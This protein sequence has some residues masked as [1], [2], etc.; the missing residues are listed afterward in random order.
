M[1]GQVLA[2]LLLL[3]FLDDGLHGDHL[4]DVPLAVLHLLGFLLLLLLASDVQ[5][6]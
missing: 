1:S 4:G 3:L 6:L 2:S 5:V